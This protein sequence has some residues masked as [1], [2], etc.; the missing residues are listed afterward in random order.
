MGWDGTGRDGTARHGQDQVDPFRRFC[1]CAAGSCGICSNAY[2]LE[3]HK[4]SAFAPQAAEGMNTEVHNI[5]S[6]LLG[7][8][9][10]KSCTVHLGISPFPRSATCL[11]QNIP[12]AFSQPWHNLYF[13]DVPAL[14]P[15]SVWASQGCFV[16]DDKGTGLHVMAFA[17]AETQ[18]LV[19]PCVHVVPLG[20]C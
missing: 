18:H 14:V 8:G 1:C 5:L 15:C 6:F 10:N 7:M 9:A 17:K 16:L 4:L 3:Q 12:G 13:G 20:I 2:E 11:D 19:A